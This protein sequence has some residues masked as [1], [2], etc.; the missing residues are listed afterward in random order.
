MMGHDSIKINVWATKEEH[1]RP[2]LAQGSLLTNVYKFHPL[3]TLDLSVRAE[4]TLT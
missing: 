2:Q 4:F 3:L 1:R